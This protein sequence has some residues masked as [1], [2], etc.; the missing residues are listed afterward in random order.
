MFLMFS[1]AYPLVDMYFTPFSSSVFERGFHWTVGW[2]E[3]HYVAKAVFFP[4]SPEGCACEPEPPAIPDS[5][6]FN[7]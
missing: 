2:P 7:S 6:V 4:P 3:T 5:N 1:S